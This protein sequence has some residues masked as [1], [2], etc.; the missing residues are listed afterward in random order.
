MAAEQR[1]RSARYDQSKKNGDQLHNPVGIANIQNRIR[2]LNEKNDEKS[3]VTINDK[4]NIPG[5][6][7]TG[8]LIILRLPLEINENEKD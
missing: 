5:Y 3:S 1:L 8:T 2:L 7:E 4:K 6:E